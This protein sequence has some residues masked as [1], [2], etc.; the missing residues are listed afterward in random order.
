MVSQIVQVLIQHGAEVNARDGKGSTPWHLVSSAGLA[1][2]VLPLIEHGADVDTK[3][4]EAQTPFQVAQS[5]RLP[6]NKI[7][8]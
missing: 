4:N 7:V 2:S 6:N 5:G 1:E 3:D 8:A